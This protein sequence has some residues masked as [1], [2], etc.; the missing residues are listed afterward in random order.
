MREAQTEGVAEPLLAPPTPQ[1]ETAMVPHL[2]TCLLQGSA[3]SRPHAADCS[4]CTPTCLQGAGTELVLYSDLCVG[5]PWA[6][7][8]QRPPQTSRA[9]RVAGQVLMSRDYLCSSGEG[10][11][12][13]T[14]AAS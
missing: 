6:S 12:S 2:F 3:P 4:S 10:P 5:E 1:L 11:G 9:H 7:G 14:A 13:H 8:S